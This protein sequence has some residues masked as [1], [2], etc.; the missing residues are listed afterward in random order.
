MATKICIG[1]FNS[2]WRPNYEIIII[3]FSN[4]LVYE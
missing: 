4:I 3:S 2:T 1:Y